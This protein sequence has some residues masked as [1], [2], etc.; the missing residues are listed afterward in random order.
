MS[1]LV[2]IQKPRGFADRN[3]AQITGDS[4]IME[5]TSVI[6]E[7]TTAL[8]GGVTG[9]GIIRGGQVSTFKPRGSI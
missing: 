4:T 5:S 9:Q 8:M 7:S 2:I 6:M 1:N 3:N